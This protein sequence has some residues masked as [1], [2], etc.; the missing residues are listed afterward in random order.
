MKPPIQPPFRLQQDSR[1]RRRLALSALL[2]LAGCGGGGG[3]GEEQ[4]A[5]EFQ[6][7]QQVGEWDELRWDQDMWS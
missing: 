4:G 5:G 1:S 2:A 6:P 7:Y 3:G